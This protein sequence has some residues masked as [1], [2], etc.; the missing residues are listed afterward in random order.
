MVLKKK[1]TILWISKGQTH[2]DLHM[3]NIFICR[4]GIAVVNGSNRAMGE[5]TATRNCVLELRLMMETSEI[6]TSVNVNSVKISD[7]IVVSS[8]CSYLKIACDGGIHFVE[9]YETIYGGGWRF[10][11]NNISGTPISPTTSQNDTRTTNFLW[12]YSIQKVLNNRTR[13]SAVNTF[14]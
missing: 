8:I 4:R 12:S 10:F 1:L 11:Y 6:S 2:W 7:L 9:D 3:N 13:A 5:N 14:N